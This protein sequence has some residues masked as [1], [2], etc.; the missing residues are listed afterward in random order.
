MPDLGR[1]IEWIKLP[2][3]TFAGLALASGFVLFAPNGILANVALDDD[4]LGTY[5]NVRSVTA[6]VVFVIAVA[7][8]L[9]RLGSWT[10]LWARRRFD[11]RRRISQQAERLRNLTREEKAILGTYLVNGTRTQK[12]HMQDGT[13]SGLYNEGFLFLPVKIAIRFDLF[14]FNIQPWVWDYLTDHPECIQ[15]EDN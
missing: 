4:S 12:L 5:A 15:A 6:G 7:M 13:V 8:L 11:T 3:T 10:S 2:T 9:A 1:L 14:A